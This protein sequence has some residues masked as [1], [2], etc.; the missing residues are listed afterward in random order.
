MSLNINS[1]II[2][3]IKIIGVIID[4]NEMEN[5]SFDAIAVI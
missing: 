5:I 2:N 3:E 4:L 1:K